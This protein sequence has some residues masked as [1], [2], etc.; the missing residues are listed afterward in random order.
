MITTA[1]LDRFRL[2]VGVRMHRR[3]PKGNSMQGITVAKMSDA[4]MKFFGET[5]R[6]SITRQIF[7]SMLDL[8]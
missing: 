6:N 8:A 2:R 7:L 5:I 4:V 1:A 3:Q